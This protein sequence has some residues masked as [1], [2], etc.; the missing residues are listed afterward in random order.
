MLKFVS[1]VINQISIFLI[2]SF[3]SIGFFIDSFLHS[4]ILNSLFHFLLLFDCVFINFHKGFKRLLLRD[5]YHMNKGYFRIY[6]L[7][8]IYDEIFKACCDRVAGFSKIY[9]FLAV[10][11]YVFILVSRNLEL[12]EI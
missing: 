5:L 3:P 8:F 6:F 11:D 9:V 7:C 10:I 2:S 12:G 4:H 1:V